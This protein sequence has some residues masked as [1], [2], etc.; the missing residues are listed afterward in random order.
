MSLDL[1]LSKLPARWQA[2]PETWRPALIRLGA[3]W[4][5]LFT[6]FAADWL[7]MAGQWWNSSTYNHV[8]LVPAI[9]L[10]L[11]WQRL[12][13]VARLSPSLFWPGLAVFALSALFW[14]L[15]ALAGLDLA[16]QAGAVALLPA[17]VLVLL[18]PRVA[19]ALAFPLG[20]MAFLVP[21]G[22]EIVP[23]LQMITARLTILLTHASAIPAEINGVFIDTPAGLFEVAEACSGVMFLVAMVAL[24]AL[25]ANVCFR[26]WRRRVLFMGIAVVTP[27]VANGVR[28]W[29]TIYVAQFKGAEYA[30]GFDHIV[31]GW[32]FFALVIALVLGIGHRF[33]DRQIDDPMIDADALLASPLLTRL[34]GMTVSLRG[35]ALA[36]ALVVLAGMG[37]AHAADR[38]H[39]PLPAQIFLPDVPGWQRI[40]YAPVVKWEPRAAGADHRLLGRFRDAAGRQ[41]DVFYALYAGQGE[42][43]EA[44]GYGEGALPPGSEWSWAGPG[45]AMAEGKTDRLQARGT[46]QR[47]AQ[48]VYRT[49]ALSTGSNARLKLAN[50]AD[51]AQ[52]RARPTMLLILSAEEVPAHPGAASLAAFRAS[53]GPLGEWMDRIGSPR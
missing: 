49:G 12:P 14:L 50:V 34:S 29:G 20:Y 51:R 52:L 27:I 37:W 1:A 28:A 36:M 40:D 2:L 7:A 13:Q 21:F 39:A 17:S 6:A 43:R 35:V 53:T 15:G 9:L 48:T 23:A 32:L 42:G 22:D 4:L 47:L 10:W 8:L 24:G 25:V 33:F 11:V 16:R 26:S 38:L 19:A 3:C 44:G 41:V 31:Y 30:T 18:G 46:V 45:P 5:A